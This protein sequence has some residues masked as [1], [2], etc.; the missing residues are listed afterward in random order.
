MLLDKFNLN[1]SEVIQTTARNLLLSGELSPRENV[2]SVISELVKL[3]DR[4]LTLALLDSHAAREAI[5]ANR[6][7]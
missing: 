3:N 5:Y 1:R 6:Q 2:D 7:N 4:E